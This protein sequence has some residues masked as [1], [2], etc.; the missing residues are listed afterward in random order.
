MKNKAAQVYGYVICV[1]AVIT[2]LISSGTLINAVMDIG[3]PLYVGFRNDINLASFENYK[4]DVLK[5]YTKEAAYVPT[6][7]ELKKMYE[8][9]RTEV[10][11]KNEHDTRK[12]LLVSSILIVISIILFFVH[13]K[14][15]MAINRKLPETASRPLERKIKE[16]V[17]N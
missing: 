13:W 4:A 7:M 5:Q 15:M 17:E 10:I 2:F 1:I 16:P 14:W 12:S 9:A 6:D 11:A 3:K 8:A